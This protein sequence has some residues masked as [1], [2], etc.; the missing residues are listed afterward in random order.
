MVEVPQG[1]VPNLFILYIN[2]IVKYIDKCKI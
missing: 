1:T 2:D